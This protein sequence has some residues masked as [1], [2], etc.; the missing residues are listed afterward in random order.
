MIQGKGEI[1]TY[2]LIGENQQKRLTRLESVYSE[3]GQWPHRSNS[4]EEQ[5]T[6]SSSLDLVDETE[7]E[8]NTVRNSVTETNTE[9]EENYYYPLMHATDSSG[10]DRGPEKVVC[11]GKQPRDS[12]T[13]KHVN[14]DIKSSVE[15]IPLLK[16]ET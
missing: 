3:T 10:A 12:A 15:L 8:E 14:G 9:S 5:I 13:S 4:N 11:N 16:N 2:W 1:L 6:F 7:N